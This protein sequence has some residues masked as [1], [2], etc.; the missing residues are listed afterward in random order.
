MKYIVLRKNRILHFNIIY[1][2]KN[3]KFGI[4]KYFRANNR[5]NKIN[6]NRNT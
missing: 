2:K 6:K 3:I 5:I 4:F 1:D